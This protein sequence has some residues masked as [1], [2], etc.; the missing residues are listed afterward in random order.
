MFHVHAICDT[1]GPVFGRHDEQL[2]DE[3][4]VSG[5]GEGRL[6]QERVETGHSHLTVAPCK[7]QELAC[8]ERGE[9]VNITCQCNTG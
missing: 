8:L 6:E 7:L 3:E 9:R 4:D 1:D 2:G 5:A